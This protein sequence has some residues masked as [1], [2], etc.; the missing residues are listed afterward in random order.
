MNILHRQPGQVGVMEGEG[1]YRE[2]YYSTQV[3]YDCS[4]NS[5]LELYKDMANLN[6]ASEIS[7]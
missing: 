2:K 1:G 7:H 6:S 3:I 4:Y 5:I